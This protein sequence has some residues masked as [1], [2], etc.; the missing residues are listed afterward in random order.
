MRDYVAAGWAEML[1]HNGLGNFDAL[2]QLQADWF[3]P[4]NQRRGGWSGVAR[5]SLK[6]ADGHG[7]GLFLKRQENHLRRTLR[8]PLAGEPTFAGEME[9][10]HLLQQAGVPALEPVY[11]GQRKVQGKWRA[12]LLTR[13][14]S[15]F[16]P[17]HT[18]MQDWLERGWSASRAE[19]F[20]VVAAAAH[21][22]R[23]LH[24]HRLVHNALHPKHVFVRLDPAAGAEIRLID[25]EKMRRTWSIEHAARR[26]LDSLNRRAR[27]FSR[28]DRLRFLKAYLDTPVLGPEGRALWRLLARSKTRF[29]QEHERHG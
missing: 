11:Y 15:G 21:V 9:N 27:L 29:M 8:H 3:E 2:W 22:I 25:L 1:R 6:A 17:L 14:L 12:V 4:P 10:I 26:D 18:L 23:R 5:I 20:A 24:T 19:R 16:V 13:E 7:E 28:S